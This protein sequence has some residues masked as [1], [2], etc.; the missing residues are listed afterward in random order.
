M[1]EPPRRRR[2]RRAHL[3][4]GTGMR[5]VPVSEDDSGSQTRP[6]RRFVAAVED[7]SAIAAAAEVA[8]LE[9]LATAPVVASGRVVYSSN[10]VFLLELD[11]PDPYRSGE[12]MRAIYKPAR[13]ERP[14][15]DFPNHSLQMRERAAYLVSAAVRFDVV[16][17][18]ALR[19]GPYGPGSIQLFIHA[20]DE[21]L[22]DA[23]AEG[24]E[25]QLRTLAAFDVIANNA[26]RKRA[27]LLVDSQAK[28]WGIDNALTFLPY[29]HQRTVLIELGGSDLPATDSATLSR[30]RDDSVRRASLRQALGNLLEPREV[31]AFDARLEELATDPWY[32]RL[33]DWEGRPFEWW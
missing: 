15:W 5:F 12:P 32:P 1:E 2:R 17:P 18:T 30:F 19:D 22:A 31:D 7:L 25:A 4:A 24:L 8:V 21:P 16:P 3:D 29:P 11:A 20:G 14:L 6:R 23:G 33:D 28:L 10:A 26:D 27:H 13:G 9:Q